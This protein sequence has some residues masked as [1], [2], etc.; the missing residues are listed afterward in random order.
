MAGSLAELGYALGLTVVVSLS[1]VMVPGPVFAAAVAKG[2]QDHMAGVWIAL[3]HGAVEFPLMALLF[4]GFAAVAGLP[5][6]TLVVG[7]AGGAVLLYLGASTLLRREPG[8]GGPMPHHPLLLGILTTASNPYFLIWWVT[9][10]LALIV[11]VYPFALAGF[12]AFAV[13]HWSCDLGW[14]GFVSA[15]VYRTRRFWTDR[16]RRGV[17]TALGVFLLALGGWFLVTSLL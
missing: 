1:G 5:E 17:S 13:A 14:N 2:Y 8:E 12:L 16:V 7:V 10:G 3:G 9:V 11:L 15:T 6:V 4:L